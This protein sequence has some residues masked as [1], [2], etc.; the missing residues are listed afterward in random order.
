MPRRPMLRSVLAGEDIDNAGLVDEIE[1]LR[2]GTRDQYESEWVL[3]AAGLAKTFD[4]GL[5][6]IP[7]TVDV[8]GSTVNDGKSPTDRNADVTVTKSGT[9]VS[10]TNDTAEDLYFLV[11]A[12]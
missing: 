10:V 11:R 3:I 2:Q 6:E 8:M 1:N 9:Q 7:W 4:H 5:D 12:M